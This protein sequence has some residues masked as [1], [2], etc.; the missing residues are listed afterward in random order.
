MS[1]R[2]KKTVVAAAILVIAAVTLLI[3][4]SFR[5][6]CLRLS[7]AES[8]RVYAKLPLAEGESFSVTF[9]HSVNKSDVTEIYERRGREIWLTGCVYYDFGAGVAEVLEPSWTLSYGDAGEMIIGGIET[10]MNSLTYI[11]G[12]VYD[13]IL[14]IGGERII[15]NE[16]CG[17]NTKVHFDIA[18]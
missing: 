16:L 15:L 10:K 17:R 6:L 5:P 14:D 12:T 18:R 3:C 7:D 1:T 2:K 11:V 13:H 9:R 4:F 8:G